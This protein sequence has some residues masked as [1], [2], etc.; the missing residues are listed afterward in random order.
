MDQKFSL[1]RESNRIPL[2]GRLFP[3]EVTSLRWPADLPK[4]SGEW[5]M[6]EI[7][8][9]FEGQ[10]ARTPHSDLGNS[11][12]V[13][14]VTNSPWPRQITAR[15]EKDSRIFTIAAN[16]KS[17]DRE[18]ARLVALR[19]DGWRDGPVIRP[20]ALAS[21]GKMEHSLSEILDRVESFGIPVRATIR[22]NCS[23]LAMTEWTI[24]VRGV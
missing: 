18:H 7:L 17:V 3:I 2:S 11:P 4:L 12:E 14:S 24:L 23:E 15:P 10:P 5:G 1:G 21:S 19:S 13:L 16:P 22:S 9:L 8:R 20:L 6:N